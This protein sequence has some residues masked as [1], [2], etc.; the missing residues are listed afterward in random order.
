MPPSV[1]QRAPRL[2]TN[3]KL[4]LP[5]SAVLLYKYS[6]MKR[7]LSMAAVA[8]AA[9]SAAAFVALSSSSTALSSRSSSSKICSGSGDGVTTNVKDMKVAEIKAELVGGV[10]VLATA[11]RAVRGHCCAILEHAFAARTAGHQ[12]C[13]SVAY[14][15]S[16]SPGHQ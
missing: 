13:C 5:F 2:A 9:H 10:A 14:Q 1:H 8:L 12:G 7:F 15:K 3:A 11:F 4:Q 6:T 16:A